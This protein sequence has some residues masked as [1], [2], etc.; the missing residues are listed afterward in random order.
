MGYMNWR[1]R[2]AE[3]LEAIASRRGLLYREVLEHS[4]VNRCPL[5]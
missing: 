4:G 3:A 2:I 1:G 5:I